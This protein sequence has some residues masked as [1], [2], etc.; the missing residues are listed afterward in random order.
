MGEEICTRSFSSNVQFRT[1]LSRERD[2][3]FERLI[4]GFSVYYIHYTFYIVGKFYI[5][6]CVH[7]FS[8]FLVFFFFF[9][10]PRSAHQ[11]RTLIET[12]SFD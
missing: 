6:K 8:S 3:F 4:N 10:Q 12:G 5:N 7:S 2:V 11:I 9:L 1:I